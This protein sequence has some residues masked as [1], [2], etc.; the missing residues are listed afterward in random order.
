MGINF[1]LISTIKW[2]QKDWNPTH[3]MIYEVIIA[4][5]PS[6]SRV[7]WKFL[8]FWSYFY[9]YLSN[10][11]I[12]D[13]NDSLL[14]CEFELYYQNPIRFDQAKD[15]AN[16][17]VMIV[18]LQFFNFLDVFHPLNLWVQLSRIVD[19]IICCWPTSMQKHPFMHRSGSLARANSSFEHGSLLWR[20][21]WPLSCRHVRREMRIP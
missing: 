1:F 17:T 6:E 8:P 9:V 13:L 14:M 3:G 10:F 21:Q 18:E 19:S 4:K 12:F 20:C 5:K 2:G 11:L 15:S 16:V 7:I